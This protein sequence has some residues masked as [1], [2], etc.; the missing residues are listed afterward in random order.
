MKTIKFFQQVQKNIRIIWSSNFNSKKLIL[1][2]QKYQRVGFGIQDLDP[3]IKKPE[4]LANILAIFVEYLL[5]MRY[6]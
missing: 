6:R 3:G 1:S 4:Y 5:Q 2:S